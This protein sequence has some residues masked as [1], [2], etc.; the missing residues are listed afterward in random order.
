MSDHAATSTG[1][2]LGNSTYD[3]LRRIVEIILP[4]AGALY[5]GASGFWGEEAFPNPEK[6][7]GT[8]ALVVVFLGLILSLSRKGYTS[9]ETET[10]VGA[11]VINNT[12]VDRPPYRLELGMNLEEIE[13]K[14]DGKITLDVKNSG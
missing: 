8:I 7:V 2:S 4:G 11:F 5:F 13:A 3:M 14:L 12:D 9:T 6:V 1:L 10:S